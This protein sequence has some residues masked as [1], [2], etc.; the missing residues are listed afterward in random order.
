MNIPIAQ[1]AAEIISAASPERPA[2]SVL[3]DVLRKKGGVLRQEGREIARA[4]FAYYRWRGWLDARLPMVDQIT[5]AGQLGLR[6]QREPET[7]TDLSPAV[8]SW[9]GQCL[10][11]SPQ[12]LQRLQTAP[13]LWLR[14]HPQSTQ[15]L[16][17][18]LVDCKPGP[19]PDSL[20]YG[21]EEDLFRTPEFHEGLFEL[22]DINSQA[23]GCVC[24]PQPGETWWDACAGEGGKT[25]HLSDLMQNKG[26]IWATDKA[27]WRLKQ[28]KIRASRAHCFNYRAKP[29]VGAGVLPTKTKFDGVLLDA[30][31]SGLGT[32][33]RNP[34]ARWTTQLKDVQEL[35]ELQKSL[36]DQASGAVKPGARLI[37][38]VC[39]LSRNETT[40]VAADFSQNHP[41]FV[42]APFANPFHPS[43][44]PIPQVTLWPYENGGNGMFI[45]A[46]TKKV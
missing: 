42:P 43:Q 21:G 9:V 17:N 5:E 37:Y 19:L 45:A 40:E 30:P 33:Q 26:L 22:Q 38:A 12:W 3:R 14:A 20:E 34:H 16:L 4:V 15:S 44:P 10:E 23:V 46:W 41:E 24:H 31:C 36:L 7:F 18:R 35:A 28:L 13:T 6:F 8:P 29:W 11:V 32:W 2:D 1:T 39:T 25:L 27:D